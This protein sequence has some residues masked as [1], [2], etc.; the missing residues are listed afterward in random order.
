MVIT[1]LQ[2][3]NIDGALVT[4][5]NEIACKLN[6]FFTNISIRLNSFNTTAKADDQTKLINYVSNKVPSE[7][8]FHIPLITPSQ[9]ATL[10]RKLD[11][12]KSTG[13][14]GIGPRIIKLSCDVI[15]PSIAD[16]INKSITSGRFPNQLKQA[17]VY[18]IFKNGAKDD[19]SNYRPISILPTISKFFEKHVNIHLMRFLN[20]HKLIHECQSG[21][22]QKHSC[23][24]ALIKLIDQWMES[25]D[26]GD[27]IGS[28]FIDFRKAFD[29]VDHPLLL[30]KLTHYKLSNA[31]LNWFQSYLSNRVQCIKSDD[32]MSE[33]SEM[34]SGVPQ[35]SILGPTLFLLF[36]NDLPLYLKHCLADL[37][38][39]DSTVHVSGKNKP[40]IEHKLQ[41][42]ANETDD[43]SIRNKLP[44]HYGK[45]TTMTL[46]TIYKLQ[47]AGQLNI[48][49]GNTP[50]NSVSSQKLLGLHIDE[51]L[52]WNKHTDYLCSVISSRISLLKHL[53]YYVPQNV[54]KMYYQSY[55]LPII[56]YGSISWGSTSKQN[57]ERINK[58]QK[59]AARI[60]LNADYI[61]PSEEMFQ[62]LDWMPVS[63]R[64]KYNKAILTY[65]ALNNL[66]PSYISDLLTPTALVYNRTLRSTENGALVIPKTNTSFY[67]GSFTCSAPKLWN[68]FPTS[69]RQAPSLNT[70]K[71]T[72]KEHIAS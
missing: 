23:N 41:T 44:I 5:S 7:T 55:I 71:R 17:K 51:T 56:D 69:I 66:T 46:G 60:I 65:K 1:K 21:F 39:D 48:T 38:A 72:L 42:D 30:K 67:T 40:E 63:N 27:I 11:P 29:M 68:T 70:F 33:F 47:Q 52:T 54:Q 58:M 22:R 35:G 18:P 34:L 26:K 15:A 20:K 16:L 57:I 24:T 2:N 28:L 64:I 32:G 6:K 36:I 62:R 45:S 12:G 31:S 61:T 8:F 25:I 53:S 19:P 9:V 14:D 37:Y 4:N 50:L 43:W 3:L 59:R 10:I 13:L 49:I